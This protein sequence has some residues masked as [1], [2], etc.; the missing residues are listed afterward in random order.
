MERLRRENE[1]LRRQQEQQAE[2]ERK[3]RQQEAQRR[4]QEQQASQ[5][6]SNKRFTV[7]GVSFTMVG[8]QGGTFQMGSTTGDS[9]EKPVHSV[10]LSSYYI[11]QT[12][13][14]QALWKAVMGSNPS[15][16]KGDNLPVEQVSW[17]DCQTFI[18]KLN[19]LTGERFR[20]PTEAEWEFAARAGS[21]TSLYNGQ[22]IVINGKNN[23]PNLDPLAWYG[24]NCG[25]NYTASEGCD[26]ANGYDISSWSEKQYSDSK[27]G[28]HP[29]GRKQPNAYGLY[30]M[31]GNVL[32]WC[33]DWYGDYSSSY[34]TNPTGP[35][36]GSYRV[37]RG[38]SWSYDATFCRTADRFNDSPSNS[39]N[40]LGLR[41]ALS[42]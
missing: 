13:V 26:V 34:Q 30:D 17:N 39:L 27:G 33:Q 1:E 6:L 4:Q 7:G 25:R 15:R 41:L 5:Q 8:I 18:S 2:A 42:E 40:R 3:R 22:D 16:F 24:G 36:S 31:L 32:E 21:R 23:S 14:T 38:G 37:F 35:S 9:D 10:T 28:T 19:S 20:L 11:G 12:E 29:V